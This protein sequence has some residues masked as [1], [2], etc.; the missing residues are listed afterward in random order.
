MARGYLIPALGEWMERS[1]L[2]AEA[3]GRAAGQQRAETLMGAPARD[4]YE[5][6]DAQ[7]LTTG[8]DS[9][10]G[11]GLMEDPNDFYN[12]MQYA[13]GLMT[14]PYF[15]QAGQNMMSQSVDQMLQAPR[16]AAESK[17]AQEN[18]QRNYQ[19]QQAQNLAQR[20]QAAA[21]RAAADNVA[22]ANQSGALYDDAEAKLKQPREALRLFDNVQTTVRKKGFSGMNI[23]DDTVMIKTLAKILQPNEA[24]MEGDVIALATME[25]IPAAVK[26]LAAKAGAGW[27]LLPEE[28]QQLYDQIFQLGEAKMKQVGTDRADFTERAQRRGMNLNDVLGTAF[29]PDM[30]N[31]SGG[32]VSPELNATLDEQHAAENPGV[33]DRAADWL[34]SLLPDT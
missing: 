26:S 12:Q 6:T 7:G 13:Q 25:G 17:L 28:R 22:M 16:M 4:V 14:T 33:M 11:S 3:P 18:W 31:R 24:V 5:Q 34:N 21:T 19:Q 30:Q 29:T 2:A 32:A 1:R 8:F 15:E 9:F 10:G 23:T 27:E 20:Q